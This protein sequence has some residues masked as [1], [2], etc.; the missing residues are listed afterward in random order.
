MGNRQL[1]VVLRHIRK[2]V[3]SA[4]TG[5]G[6]DWELL[7][8]F[9]IGH[10]EPAFEALMRRHGPMV[11]GVCRRVLHNSQ[12]ADDVFQA[13]FL[14]LI[15]KARSLDRQGALA[16]WLYTV[17]YRLALKARACSLRRRV[18]ERQI[19]DTLAAEVPADSLWSE[20]RGILD[21]EVNRLPDK[22]RAPIVLCYLEGKTNEEAAHE[23]G[24][25]FGTVS[26]RLAR[27]RD[28]LRTR[29][30]HR[31]LGL[32][33]SLFV[34]ALT[35]TTASATVP[36]ALARA[37]FQAA[38]AFP[39]KPAAGKLTTTAVVLADGMLRAMRAGRLKLAT[40]VSLTLAVIGFATAALIYGAR[41]DAP[42]DEPP[43]PQ[44]RRSLP[45]GEEVLDPECL[46]HRRSRRWPALIAQPQ[47][48]ATLVGPPCSH[49]LEEDQRRAGELRYDDRVLSWIRGAYD[50]GAIPLRFFLNSYRVISDKYGVFVYDPDA[51]FARGFA[52]SLEFRFHGWRNGVMVM[53]HA[54][55]T[56]Y[57]SLS[58]RAFDGPRKGDRL[59]PLPTLVSDW[60]FWLQAY[61]RTLAF[62]MFDKYQPV[63]L[64]TQVQHDS[65][66]S[67][68]PLDK[69]LASTTPVLG[70]VEGAQARAYPVD[71]LARVGVLRDSVDGQARILLWYGPT[72]TA[73]AYKPLASPPGED[74]RAPLGV[75]IELDRPGAAAPFIDK[76]TGSR[77]DI[78][79][80][81][82]EG[83][84]QGWTLTWLDGV[85]VKWFAW[86][87]EYPQTS[88]YK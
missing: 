73:A 9:A 26:S 79:G 7:Q 53:R 80:R 56:L 48:F 55:G 85:Q 84:L 75:T 25:P 83:R 88:I 21:E 67:R 2:L 40:V 87:A 57:S 6:I 45:P 77:W 42:A 51:G 24:C 39:A 34:T 49:C 70:V 61:P 19:E 28:L 38:L 86:A 22:Y 18:R 47:A 46:K 60:G 81:A 58:G 64:P 52:P 82:V 72:R 43:T 62:T 20:L 30:A 3:G 71:L 5:D 11:L 50:G 31:G 13:T 44:V 35:Q 65:C 29:L 27:A 66:A 78:T 15:R 8:R 17:A 16:G 54:D 23:L 59:K 12:D 32:S 33:S 36:S 37:T 63:E 10:E 76:E 68:G 14:V 4:A 1:P 41:T 69:R 74:T